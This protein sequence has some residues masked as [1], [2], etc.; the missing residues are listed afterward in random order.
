[1]SRCPLFIGPS[2]EHLAGSEMSSRAEVDWR[3]EE[4]ALRKLHAQN[5]LARHSRKSALEKVFRFLSKA[6]YR[7]GGRTHL[8]V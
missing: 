8:D 7:D 6:P 5:L 3:S 2:L 1:M 4:M